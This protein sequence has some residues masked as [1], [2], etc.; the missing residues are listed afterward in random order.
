MCGCQSLTR[1]VWRCGV[2]SRTLECKPVSYLA[3]VS[4]EAQGVWLETASWFLILL[5]TTTYEPEELQK[6]RDITRKLCLYRMQWCYFLISATSLW[7]ITARPPQLPRWQ[8]LFGKCIANLN[9][10]QM[11][12]LKIGYC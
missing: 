5:L 4:Y 10:L 2:L 1:W 8:D 11:T 7:R 9:Y 12:L 6:I 3:A